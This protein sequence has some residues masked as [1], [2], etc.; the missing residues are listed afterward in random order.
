MKRP[1]SILVLISVAFAIM[2][3]AAQALMDWGL[4]AGAFAAQGDTTLRAAGWAF[5]IWGLIY[6]WLAAFAVFQLLPSR[7]ASGLTRRL[8]WPAIGGAAATGAW[9]F[10]SAADARWASV[11][12]ITGGTAALIAGLWRAAPAFPAAGPAERGLA[13][14]PLALLAGWLTIATALNW[15]TVVTAEELL[16][17]AARTPAAVIGLAAVLGIGG[18]VAWRTR[19]IPYP[20]AI[21]WGLVA[22]WAAE[23]ARN[24]TAA[25]AALIAAGA[26]L[27]TTVV[28]IARGR[29]AGR[30]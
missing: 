19:L 21:L 6:A 20:A 9:I 2:A 18:A 8:A 24:E 25:L 22:V 16:S 5:S 10:A 28:A 4:S 11:A 29:S 1:R 27:V 26:L 17:P 7:G 30:G 15:L 3:P 12:I 23:R 14:W 13:L